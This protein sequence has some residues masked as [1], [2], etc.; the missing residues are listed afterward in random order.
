MVK[1]QNGSREYDST[2]WNEYTLAI[3]TW[4][5]MPPSSPQS[6][7]AW[8]PG[9]TSNRR[10]SRASSLGVYPSSAAILGRASCKY[11]LTRW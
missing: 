8:A 6:T 7:W 2:M 9:T 3:P 1:Q 4:A 5:R 11:I 10:C